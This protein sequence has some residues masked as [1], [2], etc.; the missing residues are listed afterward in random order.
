MQ[1]EQETITKE[2]LT[3]HLKD[4]LGLSS[5]L[6]EEIVNVFFEEI[7]SQTIRDSSVTIN[8]FGKFFLNQKEARPGQN[9]KTGEEVQVPARTVLRFVPSR[10]LKKRL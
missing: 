2:K 5:L 6:C 10:V 9:V 3:E 8:N 7:S 1:Q 4:S